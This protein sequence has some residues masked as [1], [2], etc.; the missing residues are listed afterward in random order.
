MQRAIRTRTRKITLQVICLTTLRKGGHNCGRRKAPASCAR[1][2]VLAHHGRTGLSPDPCARTCASGPI[3]STD[4]GRARSPHRTT[5]PLP[6]V[7]HVLAIGERA[8]RE[9]CACGPRCSPSRSPIC[10]ARW[11]AVASND[12]RR[13]ACV[14]HAPLRARRRR[15][16]LG[17]VR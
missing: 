13:A 4:G 15:R 10:V 14:E 12:A 6:L 17:A 1:P 9:R 7:A 2:D 8:A 5:S 3:L 16:A 11:C